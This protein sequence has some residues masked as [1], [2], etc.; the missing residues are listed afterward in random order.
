MKTKIK[1]FAIEIIPE[2]EEDIAYIEEVLKLRSQGDNCRCTRQ[3]K[4]NS[5]FID[6]VE[7]RSNK[8]LRNTLV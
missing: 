6:Y 5:S 8:E 7:I 1:R 4:S 2:T 3:N